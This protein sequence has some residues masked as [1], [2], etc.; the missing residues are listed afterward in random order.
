MNKLTHTLFS[1]VQ[2]DIKRLTFVIVLLVIGSTNSALASGGGGGG[3]GGTSIGCGEIDAFSLGSN[4]TTG[5]DP[6]TAT[7]SCGQCCYAGSDLDC[8]GDQDV[9][10]STE[11]GTWYQYCNNT[12]A[13]IDIDIEVDETNND[14][15]LQ[16][17]VFVGSSFSGGTID[18]SNPENQ[19]YGSSPGGNADGFSFSN[20]TVADGEC[21]YIY[22]DGYAGALCGAATIEIICPCIP[23]AVTASA[24]PLTVCEGS[25][26]TLTGSGATSYTWSSSGGGGGLNSTSGSSVTAN[27]TANTTYTVTGDDGSGC[28]GQATVAVTITPA[29]VP[30]AGGDL[31]GCEGET[32]T[33]GADPVYG[34]EGATYTWSSGA[35][36]TLDLTGGGQDPGQTTVSPSTTTTYTLSVDDGGCIGTDQV[37]V[38]INPLVAPTFTQEGPYCIGQAASNL[39]GTSDNGIAGS[40]DSNVSTGSAGTTTYTFTPD[41]GEC[42]TT[43]TMDIVVNALPTPN[44]G[45]DQTDCAGNVFT[46]GADPILGEN[47][48]SYSW[49][50]GDS[51]TLT[52]SGPQNGQDNG[53]ITVSPGSTT[54]YTVTVTDGNGCTNTD[55]VTVTIDPCGLPVQLV[56]LDAYCVIK[57]I[58]EWV[59]F[60]ETNNA[61]FTIERS[62]LQGDF[63]VVSTIPGR[64]NSTGISEYQ[65]IDDNRSVCDDEVLYYRLS[66]TDFD[67]SVEVLGTRSVKCTVSDKPVITSNTDK[68]RV[69]YKDDFT[70]SLLNSDGRI[71]ATTGSESNT[72]VLDI[73]NLSSGIY[74]LVIESDEL[75]T[76]RIYLGQ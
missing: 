52:L 48:A 5:C 59:T 57:P 42:A 61:Y 36:G 64:G 47:G 56:S 63:E 1:L 72:A 45:G 21:A 38:T 70:L 6:S 14:C 25:S 17:A 37:T 20:V 28:V 46:I 12:G 54:T 27:P 55:Q 3:G 16:G 41:P 23:P 10:F 49:S 8:D 40:W 66:Q 44:A 4:G 11:N 51:G 32:F 53:Q 13:T 7:G 33:I 71:I 15:N 2:K 74:M 69:T 22:I 18:C 24:S 65:F 39:P 34:T 31:V 29:P 35:S 60:S 67:G 75:H 73:V 50:T 68:V 19:E 30:D 43:E 62:C 76:E 58:I 9:S 26:V